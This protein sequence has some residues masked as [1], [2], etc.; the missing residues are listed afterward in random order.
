MSWCSVKKSTGTTSQV[1][2]IFTASRPVLGPT[3]SPVQWVPRALSLV[4]KRPGREAD[5]SP[6][7]ITE[8]KN[9]LY[10]HSSYVFHGRCFVKPRDNFTVTSWQC[11]HATY[12]EPWGHRVDVLQGTA[13]RWES[14]HADRFTAGGTDPGSHWTQR[15]L[16][17]PHSGS[18]HSGESNPAL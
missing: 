10:L 3:Q 8:F 14:S 1:L 6:P 4:I 17:G 13:Q 5:H 11:S 7:S 9:A 18:G 16:G 12:P 15:R 2:Q